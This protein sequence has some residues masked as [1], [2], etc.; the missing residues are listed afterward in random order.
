MEEIT[1]KEALENKVIPNWVKQ[2]AKYENRKEIKIRRDQNLYLYELEIH[3]SFD[4]SKILKTI[5]FWEISPPYPYSLWEF[6]FSST[7]RSAILNCSKDV[8]G[9]YFY[10]FLKERKEKLSLLAVEF[11]EIEC[12]RYICDH[13][14]LHKDTCTRAAAYG[15]LECLIYAHEHECPLEAEACELAAAGDKLECLKYL[16]ENGCPWGASGLL[17]CQNCNLRCLRYAAEPEGERKNGCHIN[18]P[19]CLS[20]IERQN[21]CPRYKRISN[22]LENLSDLKNDLRIC[23]LW[24]SSI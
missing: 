11:N 24:K 16:H 18:I 8:I 13:S 9:E 23:Q 14:I 6:V 1:L 21:I 15:N 3:S 22:Y 4:Y 17:A 10:R 5:H 2:S 19:L 12:L 20:R 7:N